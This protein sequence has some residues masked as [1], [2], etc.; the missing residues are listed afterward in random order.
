MHTAMKTLEA[1][2]FSAVISQNTLE[3]KNMNN[4]AEVNRITMGEVRVCCA[5]CIL[6]YGSIIFKIC[7]A[8]SSGGQKEL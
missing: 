8:D 4:C 1:T 2:E 5:W 6:L 7:S 3:F